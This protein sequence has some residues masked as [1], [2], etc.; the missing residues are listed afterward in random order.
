MKIAIDISQTA[1]EGTGVARYMKNFV[2]SILSQN[3]SHEFTFFY[4][5]LRKPLDNE[6]RSLI[7]SPH[8]LKQYKIPPSILEFIWNILHVFPIEYLIGKHDLFISS[9]WTEPPSSMKKITI[10]H[11]LIVFK[12]PETTHAKTDIDLNSISISPDIVKIQKRKLKWVKKESSMLICDSLSTK[13]DAEKYLHIPDERSRVIYPGVSVPHTSDH[14]MSHVLK[15]Y[16]INKPFILSVGKIEPRKNIGRLISAFKKAH[17]TD[18]ELVVVGP[19]GWEEKKVMAEQENIRFLGYVPDE[20]LFSLY[21]NAL[22]FMY[23]SLYEGFGLPIVEAMNFGCPI[24]ASNTSSIKEIVETYGLM[25]D[26]LDIDSIAKTMITLCTNESIKKQ[27]SDKSL[28]RAKDFTSKIFAQN[29]LS[30]FDTLS[31]DNRR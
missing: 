17:L 5:S 28:K 20:D 21:A 26:P 18:I 11:D 29:W 8:T 15:T 23:P 19:I 7:K 22:C 24:G 9:D 14:N 2:T 12:M 13:I 27:L 30:L 25:F 3:S 4:S 1:Y 6:I 10:L 16:Q 31:Y